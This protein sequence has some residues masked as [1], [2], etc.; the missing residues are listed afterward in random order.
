MTWKG[1]GTVPGRREAAG[2]PAPLFAKYEFFGVDG[3]R[4]FNH[5]TT[6][7]YTRLKLSSQF[8]IGDK[9]RT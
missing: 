6:K 1:A 3:K 5:R 9:N 2:A 7:R 4:P 8:R